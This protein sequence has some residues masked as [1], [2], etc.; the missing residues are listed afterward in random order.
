MLSEFFRQNRIAPLR[1][2][3]INLPE[4]IENQNRVACGFDCDGKT[5]GELLKIESAGGDFH[6][7]AK[8]F[9]R[10]LL[11][12]FRTHDLTIVEKHAAS[13]CLVSQ[14]QDAGQ[15]RVLDYLDGIENADQ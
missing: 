13:L 3:F 2:L 7:L 10:S 1:V 11:A 12:A 6:D 4:T 9:L 8:G 5:V 14:S 15:A